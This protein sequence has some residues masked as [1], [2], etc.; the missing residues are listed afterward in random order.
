[1]K[2]FGKNVTGGNEYKRKN[3]RNVGRIF[4]YVVSIVSGKVGD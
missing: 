3:G 2:L 4:L 1:M